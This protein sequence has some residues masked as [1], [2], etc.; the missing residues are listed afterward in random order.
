MMPMETLLEKQKLDHL[1]Q[2]INVL[3]KKQTWL[4]QH[5]YEL[6]I[7]F[8]RVLLFA[9]GFLVFAQQGIIYKITGMLLLSY[10]YYG[11][12]ITGTHETRHNSFVQ[13]SLGNKVWAYFFSDF[14][15]GQS[16]KWW[17]Y[18]HVV[19]H[20]VYTNIPGKETANF[21]Y[22]WL[23]KYVY[24]FLAPYLV[25]FWMIWNS[26]L[27]LWNDKKG[28]CAFL[29]FMS[30]GWIFHLFLFTR[31]L[32]LPF[33]IFSVLM[34]R[35][36][37]APVFMHLAIFNHIGL[38]D[39]PESLPWLPHQTK[40]TRNVKRHWFLTGMGG[41]A[42]VECHLEHHLFPSLSNRMLKKIRP[43]VKKYLEKEGYI[44]IEEGYW[45]VLIKC[46][47]NYEHYFRSA[48]IAV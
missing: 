24:F 6:L 46:L 5:G 7:F 42:F 26:V 18:R 28:L 30:V 17:H 41:N 32:S 8:A 3:L 37:F 38:E 22:P 25:I 23:S 34:M 35:S 19:K 2:D 11:I 13:S 29:F 43:L 44:Y 9:I 10:A 16:N 20:H 47:K 12:G 15:A 40:T 4:D 27:Y 39:P 1:T 14:W 31:L 21:Y 33:A 45:T 48:I 36:L